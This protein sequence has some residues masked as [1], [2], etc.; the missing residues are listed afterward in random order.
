MDPFAVD[1]QLLRSVLLPDISLT[2]GRELMARVVSNDA[3]GH[4]SLSIAGMLLPA[5][6]PAE[7]QAGQELKLQVRELTSDRVVFGMQPQDE[8]QAQAELPLPLAQIVPPIPP[9]GN[10]TLLVQERH[11]A[12]ADGE[13]PELASHTLALRY[14]APN[15]GPVDMYFVLTPEALHLQLTVAAGAPFDRAQ[16]LG[17]QLDGALSEAAERTVRVS[18][19]PRYDPVDVYV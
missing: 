15:A 8:P 3:A 7:L 17:G 14:E 18:I 6:L 16:R 1:L 11:S 4:G 5:E 9:S 10:G 19:K 13:D 2:L 12:H